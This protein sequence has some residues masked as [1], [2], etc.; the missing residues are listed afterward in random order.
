M[1]PNAVGEEEEEEF[2]SFDDFQ[3]VE[4]AKED[5]EPS[6]EMP[7]VQGLENLM[8]IEY[9][10]VDEKEDEFGEFDDFQTGKLQKI[11]NQVT[12]CTLVNHH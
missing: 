3:M 5:I 4:V 1:E 2:G 12:R 9:R 6:T 8:I 11:E 10:G 7:S